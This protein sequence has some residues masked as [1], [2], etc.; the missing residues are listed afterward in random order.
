MSECI[1][2]EFS[3]DVDAGSI[4]DW[5]A[6][7]AFNYDAD[8]G[9]LSNGKD[10]V[11]LTIY[12]K[13]GNVFFREWDQPFPDVVFEFVMSHPCERLSLLTV[14]D[15]GYPDIDTASEFKHDE[16]VALLTEGDE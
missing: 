15:R 6:D 9:V 16:F 11:Y 4:K 1:S 3:E 5:F 8:T 13:V 7:R 10:E 2:M 12:S 14:D